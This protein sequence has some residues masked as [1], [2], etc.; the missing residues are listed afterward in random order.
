MIDGIPVLALTLAACIGWIA[1]VMNKR[2]F[3]GWKLIAPFALLLLAVYLIGQLMDGGA[4]RMELWSKIKIDWLTLGLALAPV[5]V[6]PIREEKRKQATR[7][8]ARTA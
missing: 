6:W 1:C 7:V 4:L 8:V 5:L 3:I 2:V